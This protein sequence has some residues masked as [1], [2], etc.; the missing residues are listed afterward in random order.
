MNRTLFL[1]AL[2]TLLGAAQAQDVEQDAAAQTFEGS[3]D[4][5]EQK[6]LF[7]NQGSSA[8]NAS[9]ELQIASMP[10]KSAVT[11]TAHL[12]GGAIQNLCAAYMSDEGMNGSNTCL[13]ISIPGNARVSVS[14]ST[15]D[16]DTSGGI[17]G[18]GYKVTVK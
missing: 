10:A 13:N 17:P 18:C 4:V 5:E 8:I 7:T 14:C 15:S 16:P 2:L 11:L 9:A 1:T 12:P 3:L 6:T